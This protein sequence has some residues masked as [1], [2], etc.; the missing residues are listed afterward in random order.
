MMPV[1]DGKR[2]PEW[3]EVC[4]GSR[5]SQRRPCRRLVY[6]ARVPTKRSFVA[7]TDSAWRVHNAVRTSVP[8]LRNAAGGIDGLR[9]RRFPSENCAN[10]PIVSVPLRPFSCAK[11]Q[12]F[13]KSSSKGISTSVRVPGV[14]ALTA[15]A[16]SVSLALISLHRAF[17]STT[18]ASF[19][20]DRFC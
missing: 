4:G 20:P 12:V 5:C 16:I 14:A 13:F 17:P 19:R 7:R 2:L 8:W 11:F 15:T 18:I 10:L 3:F 1:T 9:L 6:G